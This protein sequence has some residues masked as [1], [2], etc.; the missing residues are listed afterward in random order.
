MLALKYQYQQ[1]IFSMSQQDKQN[2]QKQDQHKPRQPEQD[3]QDLK[4]ERNDPTKKTTKI[5]S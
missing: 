5:S 4:R 1:W 3:P 2:D